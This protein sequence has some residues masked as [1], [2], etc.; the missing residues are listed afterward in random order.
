MTM[1][2]TMTSRAIAE[3]LSKERGKL[4]EGSDKSDFDLTHMKRICASYSGKQVRTFLCFVRAFPHED[5]ESHL[6]HFRPHERGFVK[7]GNEFFSL[8]FLFVSW[9]LKCKNTKQQ[10]KVEW[11]WRSSN[12]SRI[13]I[14]MLLGSLYSQFWISIKTICYRMWRQCLIFNLIFNI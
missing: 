9:H 10:M 5:A 6:L 12:N 2:M 7:V 8:I 3:E 14:K 1:T 11:W 13:L 4:A